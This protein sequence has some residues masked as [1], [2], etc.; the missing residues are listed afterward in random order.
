MTETL[1]PARITQYHTEKGNRVYA[2]EVDAFRALSVNVLVLVCGSPEH[3]DYTA[4]VD[5]GSERPACHQQIVGGFDTLRERYGEQVYPDRLNRVILTHAHPDH[6][7]GMGLWR[8]ICP[9]PISAHQGAQAVLEHPK[10]EQE[11]S[12]QQMTEMLTWMGV[13][14]AVAQQEA[15]QQ[16]RPMLPAALAA[17][18]YL[19]HGELIDGRWRAIHVP[20]HASDQICIRVDDLLLTA[21]HLL[22]GSLPPLWPERLKPG[23][24]IR[25]YL[26]GLARISAERDIALAVPGHGL[27]VGDMSARISEV[28]QKLTEKAQRIYHQ[29]EQTPDLTIFELYRLLFPDVTGPRQRLL[30]SQTAA[31]MEYLQAQNFLLESPGAQ[32]SRWKINPDVPPIVR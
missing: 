9:A 12:Q 19:D 1:S 22:P 13:P 6:V 10:R 29:A 28:R 11:R 4:L 20:G 5:F 24:G 23:L 7:S 17:D 8:D 15:R 30:L 25:P 26:I 32:G 14:Q 21:D 3:P 18:E 27:A 2:M 31:V 16:A